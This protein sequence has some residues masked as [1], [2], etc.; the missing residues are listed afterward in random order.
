MLMLAVTR[1]G[2]GMQPDPRFSIFL[3]HFLQFCSCHLPPSLLNLLPLH[4]PCLDKSLLGLTVDFGQRRR[5]RQKQSWRKKRHAEKRRRRMNQRLHVVHH[6]FLTF[7]IFSVFFFFWP[8]VLQI[9]SLLP[10]FWLFA[11]VSFLQYNSFSIGTIQKKE[12]N[13]S[14]RMNLYSSPDPWNEEK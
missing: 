4:V 11:S 2:E 13:I 9:M 5:R 7:T 10:L 12:K 3:S 14:I 8:R 6:R 1:I